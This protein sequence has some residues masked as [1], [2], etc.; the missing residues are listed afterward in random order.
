MS[1]VFL[2][3]PNGTVKR[4]LPSANTT[5]YLDREDAVIYANPNLRD[6]AGKP[7]AG[8]RCHHIEHLDKS[9]LHTE[10]FKLRMRG[11]NKRIEVNG[12]AVRPPVSVDL[13]PR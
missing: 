13:G 8:P 9:L 11:G 5:K 4:V 2:L 10:I 3:N 1:V 6:A 12:A 7:Y